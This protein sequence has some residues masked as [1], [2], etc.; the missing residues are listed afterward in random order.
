MQS[1]LRLISVGTELKCSTSASNLLSTSSRRQL[2]SSAPKTHASL[3]NCPSTVGLQFA[4]WQ[5]GLWNNPTSI[6]PANT[7]SSFKRCFT[8]RAKSP[9][10]LSF[11]N[12][13]DGGW[14]LTWSSPYPSSS[15]LNKNITYEI[16][17]RK[18]GESYWT[19][20]VKYTDFG[21]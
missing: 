5:S 9:V 15:S 12:A 21:H 7:N 16:S 14:R 10:K 19:V 4:H 11:H 1:N 20:S 2:R 18:D 6:I 8:V 13:S 3:W 17:Y